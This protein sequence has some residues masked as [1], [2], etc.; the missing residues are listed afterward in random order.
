MMIVKER[1]KERKEAMVD[2]YPE[3]KLLSGGRRRLARR[4]N[5]C[6]CFFFHSHRYALHEGK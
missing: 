4:R 1:E 3:F 2:I 6:M 5:S